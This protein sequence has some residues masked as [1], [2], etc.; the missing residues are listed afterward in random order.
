[1]LKDRETPIEMGKEEFRKIGYQLIDAI[2]NFIDTIGEK[3]VTT[4]ESSKQL[5][6]LLGASSLPE[7]GT[8]PEELL[9]KA[10]ELLF[11]HSLLN[12][13]PK[14]LGYITSSAA[15]IGALA[16]LL[17]AAVNPNVG[18]NILSPIATEIEKQTVKWL[19]EFIGVSPSYGGLLV[20]G[21]KHGQLHRFFSRKNGKGA[22][23]HKGR[24][25]YQMPRND[26]LFI[27]QKP[28][29][30]G[31]KK[32]LFYLVLAQKPF[33]GYRQMPLIKWI[34]RCWNKR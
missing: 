22:E 15:P 29:I 20:S 25:A 17:A 9:S 7:K 28:P 33:A 21:G 1:M 19:A 18:A 12:G 26:W 5:Q 32:R 34:T 23:K 4:G 3:Q 30:P 10:S 13:H 11:N 6:P 14:F 2:S 31:L 8:S 16:D 24:W 27:V